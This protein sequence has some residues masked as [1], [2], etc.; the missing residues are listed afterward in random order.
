MNYGLRV[1]DEFGK[2]SLTVDSF[3]MR[4]VTI[5]KRDEI[6][7][8]GED[9]YLAGFDPEKGVVVVSTYE[10][11]AEANFSQDYS[12]GGSFPNA[13]IRFAATL[14]E[15]VSKKKYIIMGVHYR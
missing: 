15:L 2:E 8:E 13:Y 10:A 9:I 5:I 14:P 3:S 6:R 7:V 1:F 11:Q 4:A 12:V